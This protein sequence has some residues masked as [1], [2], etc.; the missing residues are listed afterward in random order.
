MHH[1]YHRL[2]E[3]LNLFAPPPPERVETSSAVALGLK[4]EECKHQPINT[5]YVPSATVNAALGIAITALIIG[6][7]A[8][9]LGL[10][11]PSI[12][13]QRPDPDALFPIQTIDVDPPPVP[14][15]FGK[16]EMLNRMKQTSVEPIR[17]YQVSDPGA[18]MLVSE[19]S[20]QVMHMTST[21]SPAFVFGGVLSQAGNVLPIDKEGTKQTYASAIRIDLKTQ[22][23]SWVT[24]TEN[25]DNDMV[26]TMLFETLPDGK[27][28]HM[29]TLQLEQLNVES[30]VVFSGNLVIN[31]TIFQNGEPFIQDIVHS[32]NESNLSV[33]KSLTVGGTLAVDG[34]STLKEITATSI[35]VDGAIE[36]QV[37]QSSSNISALDTIKSKTMVASSHVITSAVSVRNVTVFDMLVLPTPRTNP[38]FRNCTQGEVVLFASVLYIC[39]DAESP[40]HKWASVTLTAIDSQNVVMH[41]KG[42]SGTSCTTDTDCDTASGLTCSSGTCKQVEPTSHPSQPAPSPP[43]SPPAGYEFFQGF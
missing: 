22:S 21:P 35:Q 3:G 16:K 7:V 43:P 19:D 10:I 33:G 23:T 40:D 13:A 12:P 26:E 36:T 41:S 8:L 2:P 20:G 30:E 5:S 25:Q 27:G 29:Q 4:S 32:I 17:V 9:V 1:S 6:I 15:S 42:P 37:L 38:I 18:L 39:I 14:S 24:I 34:I 31:G 28:V 11:F